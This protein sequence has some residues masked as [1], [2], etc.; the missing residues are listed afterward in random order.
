MLGIAKMLSRLTP[1]FPPLLVTLATCCTYVL[2][3]LEAGAGQKEHISLSCRPPIFCRGRG[4]NENKSVI[5]GFSYCTSRLTGHSP[6]AG[7]R[8]IANEAKRCFNIATLVSDIVL[9][10]WRPSFKFPCFDFSTFEA[11]EKE[12]KSCWLL[13][14][15]PHTSR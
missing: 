1:K 6:Q 4:N 7:A 12:P 10:Q 8:G 14:S 2:P 15:S 5:S 11:A 13:H 3:L 9:K